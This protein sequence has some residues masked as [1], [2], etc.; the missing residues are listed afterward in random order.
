MVSFPQVKRIEV[1]GY[2]LYPGKDKIYLTQ[3]PFDDGP[4]MILG[5]NGLGKSTLLMLLRFLL[6]GPYNTPSP[7]FKGE[8]TK[9]YFKYGEA[10]FSAK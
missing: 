7:G 5:V 1:T 2:E 9:P 8:K 6:T 4:W 3:I 10:T